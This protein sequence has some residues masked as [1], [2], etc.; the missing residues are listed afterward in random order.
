MIET[1]QFQTLVAVANA[2][3]FS[4]AAED[5]GVT[6]SAISQSIKNL[7]NKIEVKLFRRAGKRVFLTQEGEK[8]YHLA[9]EFLERM[10]DTLDEIKYEHDEMAGKVRIGTV[11]GIGRSWLGPELLPILKEFPELVV[12]V[13]MAHYEDLV[14]DFNNHKLDLIIVAE[15]FAPPVGEKVFLSEECATLVYPESIASKISNDI[16]LDD[17]AKLPT[18]IFDPNSPMYG[19]WCKN[20]YGKIPKKVNIKF[21][22]NSHSAMLQA[23]SE[24]LGVAVIPSHVLNRS[25][26]KANV[27]TLGTDLDVVNGRFCLV[28]HKES[29][30]LLRVK[31][32]VDRLLRVKNPLLESNE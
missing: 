12:S 7:E 1:S 4:R 25:P 11:N 29:F 17:L 13:D 32:V 26:L 28:Y 6:Q 14:K 15:E 23:V 19:A 31:T 8:L 27:K 21:A 10:S 5:L 20:R 9:S 24:G 30:E 16:T 22:M 18:I 2:H 3:S